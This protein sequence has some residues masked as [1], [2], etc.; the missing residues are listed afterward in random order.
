MAASGWPEIILL[1]VMML[2]SELTHRCD[3]AQKKKTFQKAMSVVSENVVFM[4][5][6]PSCKSSLP[7]VIYE[8]GI[9]KFAN[10]QENK[11]FQSLCNKSAGLKKRLQHRLFS[12]EF[13]QI[14][15]TPIL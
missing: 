13:Y 8:K 15:K 11:V 2:K 4:G 14:F 9:K 6:V 3:Y 1:D 12:C 5:V 10:S 7:E